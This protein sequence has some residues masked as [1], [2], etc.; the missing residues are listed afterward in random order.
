MLLLLLVLVLLTVLPVLSLPLL[1]PVV[2]LVTCGGLAHEGT[3][4]PG[5]LWKPRMLERWYQSHPKDLSDLET[6][7]AH[8]DP[9][10]PSNIVHVD[11]LP[12]QISCKLSSPTATATGTTITWRTLCNKRVRYD[13]A[14]P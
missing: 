4:V 11:V 1:L 3:K 10:F 13:D 14:K 9:E 12:S 2:L 5:E 6:T 8:V 7:S